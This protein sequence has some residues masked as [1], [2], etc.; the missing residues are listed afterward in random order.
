MILLKTF[1]LTKTYK[2]EGLKHGNMTKQQNL[3]I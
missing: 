1:D 2:K 3:S